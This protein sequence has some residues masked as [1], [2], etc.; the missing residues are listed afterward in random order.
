MPKNLPG[1]V[2]AELPTLL[3]IRLHGLDRPILFCNCVEPVTDRRNP[4][5]DGKSFYGK[6]TLILSLNALG[7]GADSGVQ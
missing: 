3:G 5:Q 6:V 4:T 1:S 2:F 7:K